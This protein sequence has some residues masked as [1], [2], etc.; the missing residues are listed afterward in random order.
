MIVFNIRAILTT[1]AKV[2]IEFITN[3][4]SRKFLSKTNSNSTNAADVKAFCLQEH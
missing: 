1:A 2:L 3:K 4:K